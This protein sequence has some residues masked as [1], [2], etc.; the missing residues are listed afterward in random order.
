[1]RRAPYYGIVNGD[2][3]VSHWPIF[4]L[5]LVTVPEFFA[6]LNSTQFLLLSNARN[7]DLVMGF[8]RS[9]D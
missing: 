5:S 1:M 8:L 6:E 4:P 3:L 7:D 2:A 9:T